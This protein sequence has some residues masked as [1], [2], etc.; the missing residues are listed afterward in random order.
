MKR[1]ALLMLVVLL[2]AML[3]S[4]CSRRYIFGVDIGFDGNIGGSGNGDNTAQF[5]V[6]NGRIPMV[7]WEVLVQPLNVRLQTDYTGKTACINT[8][9]NGGIIWSLYDGNGNFIAT[10]GKGLIV[11][12]NLIGID[13]AHH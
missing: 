9:S 10:H 11:G 5:L 1:F 12:Y 8:G 3:F 7:G 4:G 6:V 2:V 13:I